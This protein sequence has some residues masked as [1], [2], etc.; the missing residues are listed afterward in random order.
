MKSNSPYC[1]LESSKYQYNLKKK[2]KNDDVYI[3]IL[4]LLFQFFL[5]FFSFLR[6][7]LSLSFLSLCFHFLCPHTQ[8]TDRGHPSHKKEH[9]QKKIITH[10]II[11]L[12]SIIL[13]SQNMNQ[14]TGRVNSLISYSSTLMSLVFSI[15][16]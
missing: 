5:S 15:Y 11:F 1:H 10:I 16:S 4:L 8:Y 14:N 3:I 9:H 6:K 13:S 2:N 12:F 7:S